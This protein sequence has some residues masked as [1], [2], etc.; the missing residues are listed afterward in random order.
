MDKKVNL[1]LSD[2]ILELLCWLW[3]KVFQAAVGGTFNTQFISMITCVNLSVDSL[4]WTLSGCPFTFLAI[5]CAKECDFLSMRYY[6]KLM[7]PQFQVFQ[8]CRNLRI[9]SLLYILSNKYAFCI[10]YCKIQNRLIS[11]E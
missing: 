6:N 3:H 4:L 5:F 8:T 10:L 11:N 9:F 2:G 1:L 7:M